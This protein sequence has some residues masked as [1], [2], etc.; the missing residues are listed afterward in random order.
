MKKRNCAARRKSVHLPTFAPGVRPGR[1]LTLAASLSLATA[2]LVAIPGGQAVAACVQSGSTVTCSGAS[3]TGFGTGVENNLA[4]TVQPDAS[5]SVGAGQS[6]VNL[7]NGNTAINNGTIA[8]GG[9]GVGMNGINNNT[10][11]N[12]GT[13]TLGAGSS[14]FFLGTNNVLTN[15]GTMS[16]AALNSSGFDVLGNGN[17]V[18]NSG[19]ITLTG[20]ASSGI[21]ANSVGNTISNSGVITVGSSTGTNGAG[22]WLQT[23]NNFTNTGTITSA[24]DGGDAITFW[25]NGNTLTNSGAIGATGLGGA[26]VNLVGSNNAIVN[27][28]TIKGGPNGFSLFSFFGISGGTITNN[29]TLD[30]AMSVIGTGVSLTNAGLITI[31]DPATALG[32]FN[33]A[34]SGTFTQT[35]Q[36]TLALRVNNAGQYDGVSVGG[37]NL[38]GTLRV[39]LQPG[40]YQSSTTYTNLLKSTTPIAGQFASV[41]SSAFFNAAATYNPNSVDLTLTRY[42]FGAV[43]GETANQRSIGNA[44]EAGYST[45]LTGPAATFYTQLLQAGSPRVLDQ[46]SG[47][48]TS[49]T[50]NT[51]FTAGWLFG[52]TLD[53]Q[54]QAWRIG[55]RG[56]V[57]NDAALGYA[58]EQPTGPASAFNAL[59]APAMVQPQWHAWAAGFGAAQSLTGDA[60]IG[61]A[62]FDDRVAGGAIGVDRL[63]N[64]DLLIGVAA[65]GSSSTFSVDDRATSGRLDGAHLGGYAM[66]RFGAS[67]FSAQLAYS[68]FNNSTTRTISAIGPDEIAKGSFSSD[69]VGG[70]LEIGRSFDFSSVL[71]TPFAAVEAARLWQQAYSETSITGVGPGVLGLSYA[72]HAVFSLPVFLGA[73][74][75]GRADLGN[76]MILSPF[77]YAAWVHEFEPTRDITASLI[78]GPVSAFTIEGAR[79]AS[80]AGRVDIGSRLVLNRWWE[81]SARF[82]GEFSSVGQTYAGMGSLRVN[83]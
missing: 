2:T 11:T 12:T 9:G 47:E 34:F 46:L 41:S 48:G 32:P 13:I 6:A 22:V 37:A 21:F 66:Q 15:T 55:N 54:M 64:P 52:Q 33:I 68:H 80:D 30:G 73:R 63:V 69:Q 51:A 35:A 78:T 1:S 74:F 10:F 23:S 65:G 44:L 42:G 25:G 18:V 16:S 14:A 61:S 5:I 17:T 43:P 49:G 29:G 45:A 75:D 20:A 62:S 83:W 56:N 4:L 71:V 60:T 3:S 72:A 59:K 81:L 28:G 77:V 67:Y 79:A 58:A 26:G 76:G 70:R 38:N 24:G 39:V 31:T 57:I 27:N 8:V 50:Q 19:T 7:G 36:G 82:T 40:L 53:G